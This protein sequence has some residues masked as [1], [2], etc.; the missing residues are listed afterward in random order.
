MCFFMMMMMMTRG[1]LAAQEDTFI[2][3]MTCAETL[4]FYAALALPGAASTRREQVHS[5]LQELGLKKATHT[6]VSVLCT[7]SAL[8]VLCLRTNP[9][10]CHWQCHGMASGLQGCLQFCPC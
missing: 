3:T 4:D 10:H 1:V 8:A 7:L 6:M 2:P 9:W 5:V